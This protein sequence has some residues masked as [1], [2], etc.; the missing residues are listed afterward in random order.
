[1]TL[2][3]PFCNPTLHVQYEQ[4]QHE[5]LEHYTQFLGATLAMHDPLHVLNLIVYY[6]GSVYVVLRISRKDPSGAPPTLLLPYRSPHS[7]LSTQRSPTYF[8][9]QLTRQ[10]FKGVAVMVE[11]TLLRHYDESLLIIRQLG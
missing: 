10:P 11:A 1:M 8:C 3:E 2:T 7:S 9:S 5:G 4:K 6:N